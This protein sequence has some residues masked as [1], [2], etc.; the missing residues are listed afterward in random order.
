MINTPDKA[1]AIFL[2]GL[3]IPM[4]DTDPD[5]AAMSMGNYLLGGAPLASRL[6]NRVRGE[7][8]LSYGVGSFFLAD[9]TDKAGMVQIFAITNPANMQKVDLTIAEEIGKF[10]KEGVSLEELDSG[11]K[12]FIDSM[13]VQRTSDAGLAG[14]LANGLFVGRKFDYY[15][16]LEKKIE[17]LSPS[18]IQKAYQK[19]L[20][21]KKLTIIQAGDFEKKK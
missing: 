11:K 9:S 10:L 3:G 13:K 6:S 7:K 5:F 20:D 14:Q 19:L 12:G 8:G 2:A 16:E 18:E 1:N 4:T 17:S 21:P 15:T